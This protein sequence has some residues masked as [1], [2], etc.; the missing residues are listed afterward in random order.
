M[1]GSEDKIHDVT[2]MQ[3]EFVKKTINFKSCVQIKF[4]LHHY[5]F[6]TR[7][8]KQD[9]IFLCLHFILKKIIFSILNNEFWLLETN[10]LTTRTNDY[11]LPTKN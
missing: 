3:R 7:S 5:F 4:Q 6:M 9:H 2:H 8:S 1:H 11:F 10:I